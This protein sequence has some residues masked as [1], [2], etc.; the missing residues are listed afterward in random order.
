MIKRISVYITENQY[1]Y[2]N[3]AV[4]EY[5][6]LHTEPGECILFLWQ[7]RRT[8]VIGKNQNCWK[9]C[10]VREL[11]EA[12]GYLVRRLSGG[13][14]VFHDLGNLNFTFCVRLEDYSVERQTEVI[15]RAVRKLGIRAE[16]SGRNDLTVDGKKFSGNAFYRSGDY[17][18]HHGTLLV[19]VDQKQM[20]R[21][22]NVP[23]EKLRSN[24]V[25]SVRARTVNLKSL[26]PDLTIKGLQQAL[27][28]SFAEVY[29]C[30]AKRFPESRLDRSVIAAAEEKFASWEWKYG[31]RI[32]F[33]NELEHR[34]AWGSLDLQFRIESG[35]I[36]ELKAYTDAMDESLAERLGELLTGCRYDAQ[37][38]AW[39]LE[40]METDE[41]LREDIRAW[42]LSAL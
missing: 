2:K 9:E 40:Y 6:T 17:C 10:R 24:G 42:F 13:G 4:E 39:R 16:R 28:D 14:A 18:Y 21:Y 37:S 38:M 30:E 26:Q 15:L 36:R 33:Q 31:S 35:K 19:D 11:E 12:G 8:V 5:L 25:E 22:L 1:P 34:F 23:R 41:E 29:G 27:T 7:N 32:S 20:S 3:L